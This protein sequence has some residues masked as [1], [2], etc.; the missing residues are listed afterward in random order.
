VTI[1]GVEGTEKRTIP[2]RKTLWKLRRLCQQ[3]QDGRYLTGKAIKVEIDQAYLRGTVADLSETSGT[4]DPGSFT[5]EVSGRAED[6]KLEKPN[7]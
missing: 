4:L 2:L 1:D 3:T 7:P 5:Q 6:S